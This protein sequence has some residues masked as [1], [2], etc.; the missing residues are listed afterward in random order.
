MIEINTAIK[1]SEVA[2]S[3]YL[4]SPGLTALKTKLSH[5]TR[6]AREIT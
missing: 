4:S 6:K 2:P 3:N 1:N 5:F